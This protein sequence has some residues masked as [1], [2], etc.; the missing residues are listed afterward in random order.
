MINRPK[1]DLDAEGPPNKW[2]SG[3]NLPVDPISAYQLFLE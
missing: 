1:D 3:K 2:K